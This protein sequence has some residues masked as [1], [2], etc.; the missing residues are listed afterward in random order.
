MRD[1]SERGKDEWVKHA[2]SNARITD[3]EETITGT[4]QLNAL[5]RKKG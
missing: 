2:A 5:E 3:D 4:D 1:R